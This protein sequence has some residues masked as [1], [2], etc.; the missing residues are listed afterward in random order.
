MGNLWLSFL[1]QNGSVESSQRELEWFESM[2][3]QSGGS[4]LSVG[5]NVI[6]IFKN[7]L[8]ILFKSDL[9]I[10]CHL[11]KACL[12]IG[13]KRLLC[14][15]WRMVL[16]LAF[17]CSGN[18]DFLGGHWSIRCFTPRCQ[19]EKITFLLDNKNIGMGNMLNSSYRVW[20]VCFCYPEHALV[21]SYN[22]RQVWL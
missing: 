13:R 7:D 16:S 22:A 8:G 1:G 12:W 5:G 4:A 15:Q 14:A 18:A 9:K 21:L 20:M 17:W 6:S 11:P 19:D 2:V 10:L 3:M